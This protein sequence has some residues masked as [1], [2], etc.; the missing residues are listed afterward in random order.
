[1]VPYLIAII[2]M[3]QMEWATGVNAFVLARAAEPAEGVQVITETVF[4]TSTT[5]VSIFGIIEP[6]VLPAVGT[7]TFT[8]TQSEPTQ[9]VEDIT[10]STPTFT[11]SVQPAPSVC[12][13]HGNFTLN[14]DGLP[15]YSGG[16]NIMN[17][18]YP[19]IFNPYRHFYFS[20][21]WGYLGE[22]NSPLS[23]ESSPHV[24]IYEPNE[25]NSDDTG[26]PYAG[27]IPPG[28]FGAG[29][30]AYDDAY[31]F[32]ANSFYF[33]CSNGSNDGPCNL[34][35]TGIRYSPMLKAEYPSLKKNFVID[36][37]PDEAVCV[38]RRY[39]LPADMVGLTGLG[40]EATV[41]DSPVTWYVDDLE[42]S[43]YN[44][45]CL[46]GLKRVSSR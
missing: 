23:P 18:P 29:P 25:N 1:M 38:L 37:C 41:L 44:N 9:P 30:R 11:T 5:T 24:A 46:A 19:P 8:G 21:G 39:Q 34:T 35:V 15:S 4:V 13:E 43:W 42:L 27:L 14:F 17:A 31:W 16:S 3:A 6:T 32:N 22:R 45:T 12:G 20:D 33:G 36:A 2:L 10:S 40:F 26:S 28:N 7:E